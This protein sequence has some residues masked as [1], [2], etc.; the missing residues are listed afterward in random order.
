MSTSIKVDILCSKTTLKYIDMYYPG[1][2]RPGH[3]FKEKEEIRNFIETL[4][5]T[6][7]HFENVGGE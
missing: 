2:K 5:E 3:I 1:K 4:E 6:V 7:V